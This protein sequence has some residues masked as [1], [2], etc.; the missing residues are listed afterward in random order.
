MGLLGKKEEPLPV[1]PVTP[2]AGARPGMPGRKGTSILSPDSVFVGDLQGTDDVQVEGRVEGK[3]DV[4]G[5]FTVASSGTVKAEVHARRILISGKVIGN[6]TGDESVELHPTAQLEGNITCP[7]VV[8]QEGAQF[9]GS[10]DMRTRD[11]SRPD[12]PSKP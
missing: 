3:V 11:G 6:I 7:K 12:A 2:P 1:K 8:I 10:V 4:K 5:Q 9:K